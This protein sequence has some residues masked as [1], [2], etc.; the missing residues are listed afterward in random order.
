MKYLVKNGKFIGKVD[1]N[2]FV[3]PDDTY[4]LVETSAEVD[5]TAHEYRDGEVVAVEVVPTIP[6]QKLTTPEE[7]KEDFTDT[8]VYLDSL[9]AAK[10]DSAIA[11]ELVLALTAETRKD[12]KRLR[13][14]NKNLTALL[15][16][17]QP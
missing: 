8:Q 9:E 12:T 6:I 13:K 4:I 11:L 7:E 17:Q 3:P 1:N 15:K 14:H 2:D 10:T 16:A 5:P